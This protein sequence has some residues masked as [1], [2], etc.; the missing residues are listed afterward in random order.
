MTKA[1]ISRS[2]PQVL[3]S[4]RYRLTIAENKCEYPTEKSRHPRTEYNI[5]LYYMMLYIYNYY[6]PISYMIRCNCYIISYRWYYIWY[7]IYIHMMYTEYYIWY[8][9]HD[10]SRWSILNQNYH[11]V[12]V[13]RGPFQNPHHV[14]TS[15]P[16]I[17]CTGD[18]EMKLVLPS[19]SP[20][21]NTQESI[22]NLGEKSI[23][24]E[25]GPGLKKGCITGITEMYMYIN[26]YI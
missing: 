26:I 15:G 14:T 17:S 13:L 19:A 16:K 23:E 9:I 3:Q 11:Q 21:S 8:Y 4:S 24:K 12:T 7:Y 25:K 22:N 5:S 6:I 10:C 18:M 1:H 20:D 2:M